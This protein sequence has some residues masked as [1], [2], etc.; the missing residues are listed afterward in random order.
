MAQD[1]DALL[2]VQAIARETKELRGQWRRADGV[3]GSGNYAP[4][5]N[6]SHSNV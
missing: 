3:A 4:E 5:P 2:D 1:G 6:A